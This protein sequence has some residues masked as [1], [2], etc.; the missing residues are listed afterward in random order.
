MK[1]T[2]NGVWLK[3]TSLENYMTNRQRILKDLKESVFE[4]EL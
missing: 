1:T 3:E 4:L 2:R